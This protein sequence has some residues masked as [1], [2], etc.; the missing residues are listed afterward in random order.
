MFYPKDLE[1]RYDTYHIATPSLQ[2]SGYRIAAESIDNRKDGEK[3]EKHGLQV[4]MEQ[5]TMGALETLTTKESISIYS[6]LCYICP[7]KRAPYFHSS[8]SP[9]GDCSWPVQG[10]KEATASSTELRVHWRRQISESTK[11]ELDRKNSGVHSAQGCDIGSCA[12][13]K[14]LRGI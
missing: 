13:G 6:V 10:I 4:R 14:P 9:S 5:G 8:Y 7:G 11:Y 12:Q 1:D 2:G 3:E